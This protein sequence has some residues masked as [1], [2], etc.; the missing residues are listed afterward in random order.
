MIT[1][2]ISIQATY[3]VID[4]DDQVGAKL[5]VF[6]ALTSDDICYWLPWAGAEPP[7]GLEENLLFLSSLPETVNIIIIVIITRLGGRVA[8]LQRCAYVM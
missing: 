7:T 1:T 6:L 8:W 5:G 4:D 3:K 2:W